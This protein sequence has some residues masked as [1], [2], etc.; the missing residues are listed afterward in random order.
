MNQHTFDLIAAL[1]VG[2]LAAY[3]CLY[4]GGDDSSGR[5]VITP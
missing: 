1:V 4:D 5:S 3:V 2:V